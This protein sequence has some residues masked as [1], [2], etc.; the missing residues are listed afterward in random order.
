MA[1]MWPRKLP[2]EVLRNELRSAERKVFNRLEAELD[3]SWVVFYSRPWLGLKPDGEEVDGE[4]DFLLARGDSGFLAIE[5]KGGGIGYDPKSDQWTSQDRHGFRHRIKNPVAQARSSKYQILKKLRG[6]PEL[7][8]RRLRA[9][10]AVILPDAESVRADL[11]PD[12]PPRLFCCRKDFESDLAGWLTER[13]GIIDDASL[14]KPLGREGI[15]ALET[16]LARPFQIRMTTGHVVREDDAELAALTPQ[17][18]RILSL[19]EEVPRAAVAGGAG[20]GKTVLAIEKARRC[21]EGGRRTL[22]TC[23]NRPLADHLAE[24]LRNIPR[25]DVMTFHACC[26]RKAQSAGLAV[27]TGDLTS[28]MLA[29]TF[30]DLLVDAMAARPDLAYDAVV[31]DEGQDFQAHWWSAVDSLLDPGG[32][33]ILYIFHDANQRVYPEAA[34]LPR[35]VKAPPFPLGENLRNTQRINEVLR[36]HYRG[37]PVVPI[38]PMGLPVRWS[39]AAKGELARAIDAAV[40]RCTGEDG[41]RPEDLAVLISSEARLHELC[42]TGR[43]GGHPTAACGPKRAGVVTLDTVRRFKGLESPVVIL[44][45]DGELARDRE[46]L[47][48]ALSRARAFLLVLGAQADLDSVAQAPLP[49]GADANTPP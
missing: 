27:P 11:G 7:K 29:N 26:R 15:A 40:A 17:Q 2:D 33:G 20:T 28:S 8:H 9:A 41:I 22:L 1:V 24:V 10:H 45:I 3:D 19:L 14:E 12:M 25:L 23:F 35:E 21:A 32:P 6:L 44:V 43:L 5:V 38:G 16:I 46:M 31:V 36:P 34:R 42:P 30:P 13:L 47:Y 37:P 39:A 48:V 4:C 49:D 18:Y